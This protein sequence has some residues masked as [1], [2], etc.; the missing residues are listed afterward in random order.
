MRHLAILIFCVSLSI[1]GFSQNKIDSLET[2]LKKS[3]ADTTRV[4]LYVALSQEYQYSNYPKSKEYAQQAVDL[5]ERQ[6]EMSSKNLA[7]RNIGTLFAI[8]GD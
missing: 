7:Y 1:S 5:A 2:E 3:L 8:S 4:K 6:N